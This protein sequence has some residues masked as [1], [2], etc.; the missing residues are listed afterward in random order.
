[1]AAVGAA[2][3]AASA[4]PQLFRQIRGA[5]ATGSGQPPITTMCI[6]ESGD[7]AQI[8]SFTVDSNGKPQPGTLYIWFSVQHLPAGTYSYTLSYQP[9]S[10][11]ST[12]FKL[13]N[14]GG[15]NNVFV[16]PL[17]DGAAQVPC[18]SADPDSSPP[19][20]QVGNN[21]GDVFNFTTNSLGD[22]QVRVHLKYNNGPIT[23]PVVYTFVGTLT[24]VNT[25]ATYTTSAPVT[26]VPK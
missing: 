11:S 13:G 26:A 25:S 23:S 8:Q 6:E 10:D 3:A 17:A 19:P 5:P 20:N 15:G 12:P 1:V 7:F 2:G 22:F 16:F 21:I 4:S 14:G 9:Y 18:P 24:E